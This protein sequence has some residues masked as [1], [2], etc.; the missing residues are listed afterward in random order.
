MNPQIKDRLVKLTSAAKAVIYEPKRM[1]AFLQLMGTKEGAL[2][3]VRTVMAA[4]ENKT[5]ID[6]P[7]KPLLGV[8]IYMVMV[9]VAQEVLQKKPSAR[10]IKEV[11]DMILKDLGAESA[12][13]KAPPPEADPQTPPQAAPQGMLGAV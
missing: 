12:P 5:Q 11:V 8:N 10:V 9:D 2:T 1:M 4:I 3:A 7:V 13:S 6:A